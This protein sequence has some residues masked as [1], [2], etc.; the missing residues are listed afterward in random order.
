MKKGLKRWSGGDVWLI[1]AVYLLLIIGLV[2]IYSAS[3]YSASATYNDSFYFV[4]KQAVGV[5][6]G[7]LLYTSPSPRDTR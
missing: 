1:A 3:N 6:V 5:V 7:C 2:F 4:K